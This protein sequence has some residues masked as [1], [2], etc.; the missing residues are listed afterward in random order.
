MSVRQGQSQT[1]TWNDD[2]KPFM[3]HKTA[4]EILDNL[5]AYCHPEPHLHPHVHN[6][7]PSNGPIPLLDP[8]TQPSSV[9][10]H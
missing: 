10:N 7:R 9:K 3:W 6:G 4:D 2:P 1:E 8:A 5:A